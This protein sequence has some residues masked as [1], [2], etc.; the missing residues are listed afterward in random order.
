M[1]SLGLILPQH[2]AER[3]TSLAPSVWTGAMFSCCGWGVLSPQAGLQQR[4]QPSP[5]HQPGLLPW[6]G[7]RRERIRWGRGC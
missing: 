2:C 7:L 1:L 6:R 4:L 5:E 3:R